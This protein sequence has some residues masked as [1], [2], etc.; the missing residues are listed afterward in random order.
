MRSL[1]AV[2]A[3]ALILIELKNAIFDYLPSDIAIRKRLISL[4]IF[5]INVLKYKLF[6]AN[7]TFSDSISTL[8]PSAL[9]D[10]SLD[11]LIIGRTV[12][13]SPEPKGRC[14]G[15]VLA[16][17]N[18][19]SVAALANSDSNSRYDALN[20]GVSTFAMLLRIT[21]LRIHDA[22]SPFCITSIG[23]NMLF[24]IVTLPPL[25]QEGSLSKFFAHLKNYTMAAFGCLYFLFNLSQYI[26]F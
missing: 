18:P 1:V 14:P 26:A 24:H 21:A 3:D 11:C 8:L 10:N 4:F 23:L 20:P 9:I 19:P 7:L 2:S 13:K 12:L 16:A 15:C 17:T 22:E 6:C 25:K 5:S